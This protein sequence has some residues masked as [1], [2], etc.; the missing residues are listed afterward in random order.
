MFGR[1]RNPAVA[2]LDPMIRLLIAMLI[3]GAFLAGAS[4]QAW[5]ATS[6]A[7]I[8]IRSEDGSMTYAYVPLD[9]S[10]NGIE[11]LRKSG[12]PVV[13]IG[14]GGLGDGVCKIQQTGCDVSSC[15]ARLCQTGDRESPYWRYFQP[16]SS[17]NWVA[18]PLG[19]S[20]T[21][22][23][24]GEIDG[25]SWT[26]EASFL[27][28]VDLSEIPELAGATGDPE[29]PHFATYDANG[30]LL[31]ARDEAGIPVYQYAEFTGVL[32]AVAGF[33]LFL[34]LRPGRVA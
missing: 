34:R 14:F 3:G 6:Y 28:A 7:G 9:E 29:S 2:A 23:Q 4:G 22:V 11:L 32:I 17:G 10:T 5:S 25:W 20:A 13:T 12:V 30:T 27:P 31:G 15:R 19:G 21:M 16:D 1:R 24:P 26:P 8:V 33:G 18:A